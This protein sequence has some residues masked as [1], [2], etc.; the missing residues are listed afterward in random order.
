MIRDVLGSSGAIVGQT[1]LKS[2]LLGG[3]WLA[4]GP[5]RDPRS[6]CLNVE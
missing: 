4:Q 5:A 6:G 1:Q 3:L 2:V